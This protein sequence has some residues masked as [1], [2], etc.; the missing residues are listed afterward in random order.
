[1]ILVSC[2]SFFKIKKAIRIE[3]GFVRSAKLGAEHAT[4]Y[5]LAFDERGLYYNCYKESDLEMLL[6]N[7]KLNQ[8]MLNHA[9]IALDTV[10]KLGISKYNPISLV[11]NNQVKIKKKNSNHWTSLF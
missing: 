9:E 4:P 11:A 5:S 8:S 3:D 2:V 10:K 6:N 7:Y 1:M